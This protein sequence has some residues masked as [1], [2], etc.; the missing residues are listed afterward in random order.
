M[1]SKAQDVGILSNND[2]RVQLSVVLLLIFIVIGVF[3]VD[4]S[5]I[6]ILIGAIDH[7][8]VLLTRQNAIDLG[9]HLAVNFRIIV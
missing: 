8:F 2:V 5:S 3:R 6:R 7:L 9:S 4:F 1:F